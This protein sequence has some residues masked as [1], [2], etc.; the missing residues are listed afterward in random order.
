MFKVFDNYKIADPNL[1]N[2]LEYY[3]ESDSATRKKIHGC[4]SSENYLNNLQYY[5]SQKCFQFFKMLSL[6]I[7]YV[8]TKASNKL[9]GIA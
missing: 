6:D 2:L 7:M 9:N 3:R 8:A 1:E 5:Y 4:N